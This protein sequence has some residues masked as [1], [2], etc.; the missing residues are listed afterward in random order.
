MHHFAQVV[1]QREPQTAAVYGYVVGCDGCKVTLTVADESV[2]SGGY[3]LDAVV[4]PLAGR[5]YSHWKAMLKPAPAGGNM[6]LTASM[7][8]GADSVIHDATFGDVW[9]CSGQVRIPFASSMY[10][11]IARRAAAIASPA[12]CFFVTGAMRAAISHATPPPPTPAR[13]PA[14]PPARPPARATTTHRPCASVRVTTA[15]TRCCLSRHTHSHHV[16][17]FAT[18]QSN[19]WLV[20][21]FDTSSHPLP[22]CHVFRN[23][24]EQ[25]VARDAL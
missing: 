4:M 1:L 21:H 7:G 13:Q 24:T 12:S 15:L 5:N 20:M 2:G 22:P 6:T 10:T 3:E 17:S 18:E 14:R 9:F 11:T 19:M 25:H 23:R 16:M 8:K